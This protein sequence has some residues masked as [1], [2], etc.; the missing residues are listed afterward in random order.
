MDN[1]EIL[2]HSETIMTTHTY[3]MTKM[4]IT[5]NEKNSCYLQHNHNIEMVRLEEQPVLH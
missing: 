1:F 5:P 4:T 2:I 3:L